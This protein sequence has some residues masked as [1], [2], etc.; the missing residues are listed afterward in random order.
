VLLTDNSGATV[1]VG[2]VTPN[3]YNMGFVEER[4]E[5]EIE[6]IDGL[7]TLQYIKYSTDK[8]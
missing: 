5:V 3:L 8:K 1:W 2:Y 7:S 4:E 6:C